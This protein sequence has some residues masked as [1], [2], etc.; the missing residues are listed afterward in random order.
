MLSLQHTNIGKSDQR[1]VIGI[2]GGL[3]SLLFGIIIGL[4]V[5]RFLFRLLG[6]NPANGI[7]NWVYSASAP[8][9]QPFF[10]M[11]NTG[12]IDLATGRV[13]FETLI[14]IVAYGIIA[15]IISSALSWG[16]RRAV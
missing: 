2:V 6:A 10:G 11:F 4:L 3:V 9:V 1:G 14:A 15:A 5:F 16:R 12:T 13:E 7:V 8:F